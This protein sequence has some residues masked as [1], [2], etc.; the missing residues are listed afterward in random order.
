MFSVGVPG[1]RGGGVLT[2]NALT[3][4][5]PTAEKWIMD[6]IEAVKSRG[7]RCAASK[8]PACVEGV[9]E[10]GALSAALCCP[11]QGSNIQPCNI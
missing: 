7:G 9:L 2:S 10:S 4:Q 11:R 6:V 3:E 1:A 8:E 5:W